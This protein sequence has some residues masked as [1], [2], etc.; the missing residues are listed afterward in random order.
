[1]PRVLVV[2]HDIDIADQ[3]AATLRQ[4]GYSVEQCLG[5]TG[6]SCP[7][8]RGEPCEAAG[9]ADVLLYDV[10][11]AGESDGG[12]RL[13]RNLRDLHPDIP[14]VLTA[15]GLE[16]DWVEEQGP[17]GVTALTGSPG[18]TNLLAAIGRALG[19]SVTPD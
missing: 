14:V 9:R 12:R 1:M 3:E 4:A 2:H 10:W 8:M 15:P 17:H 16:L 7:V 6:G 5:P 19:R 18:R 13:I 11:A